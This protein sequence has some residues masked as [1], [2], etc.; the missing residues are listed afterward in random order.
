MSAPFFI[1]V[2]LLTAIPVKING[3][4]IMYGYNN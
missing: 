1:I 3:I 4:A 2:D